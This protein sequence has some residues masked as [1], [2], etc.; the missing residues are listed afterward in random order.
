MKHQETR[1]KRPGRKLQQQQLAIHSAS[2]LPVVIHLSNGTRLRGIVVGSDEYMVLLAMHDG[3]TNPQL[4]YK[5]SI[6]AVT[7]VPADVSLPADEMPDS[8][9]FVPIFVPRT[10]TRRKRPP[11]RRR[12]VECADTPAPDAEAP[13]AD[14]AQAAPL[15]ALQG[16]VTV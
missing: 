8:P 3:D 5:H 4:I 1:S 12:E 2:R 16:T 9:D 6:S 13:A 11:A 15:L 10:R 14:S 7:Q